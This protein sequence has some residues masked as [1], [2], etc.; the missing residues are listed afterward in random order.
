MLKSELH[1]LRRS[2]WTKVSERLLLETA[3]LFHNFKN[4]LCGVSAQCVYHLQSSNEGIRMAIHATAPNVF[5]GSG[6]DRA[7]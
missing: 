7:N 4:W 5:A 6:R 2:Q 3:P 1:Q